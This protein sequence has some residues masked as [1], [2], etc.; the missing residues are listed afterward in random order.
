[1]SRFTDCSQTFLTWW[2][3]ALYKGVPRPLRKWV[4]INQPHLILQ[5]AP[6][7]AVDVYWQQGNVQTVI[8]N[9]LL[10]DSLKVDLNYFVPKEFT[11]KAYYVDLRLSKQQILLLQKHYPE[12]VKD[13]LAQAVR[14][15]IDRLTPFKVGEVY[16]DVHISH[17]DRK[18]KQILSDIF[19]AP[20]QKVDALVAQLRDKGIEQ[21]DVISVINTTSPASLTLDGNPN[22][23]LHP[24]MS[25]RPLYFM[26]FAVL[27]ALL[28]PVAYQSYLL[29][30]VDAQLANL[31]ESAAEQLEI[32][33]K[34]YEAE[35][36]LAFLKTKRSS[37]PMALDIVEILTEE[38]PHNT[39]LKRLDIKGNILEIRGESE[40]ALALID[41]LE[42]STSFS[43]VRFNSPVSLNKI[44]RR[45]K[46]YIQATLEIPND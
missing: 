19:I 42:E 33:D 17:H 2:N 15:Q 5:V 21:L 22:R 40:K 46:F 13:N 12:T 32:R 39:W 11:N 16:F 34:L 6:N 37:S 27:M 9:F 43:N 24:N 38:I 4:H 30:Q 10:N 45:D 44:N 41:V 1:M 35:Q 23:D 36:A 8:G 3:H 20:R 29:A 28:M 18:R 14:Y 31:G 7:D 26:L 25:R